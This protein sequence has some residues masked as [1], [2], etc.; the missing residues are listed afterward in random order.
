MWRGD[1]LASKPAPAASDSFGR[2]GEALLESGRTVRR[3]LPEELCYSV[4]RTGP[5]GAGAIAIIIY[6]K[7][8]R[9]R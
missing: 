8:A 7:V 6:G 4:G 1:A 3:A 9:N 5:S 2:A